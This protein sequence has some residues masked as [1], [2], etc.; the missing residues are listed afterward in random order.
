[1]IKC[2]MDLVSIKLPNLISIILILIILLTKYFF[3]PFSGVLSTLGQCQSIHTVS[4]LN[5]K[6]NTYPS[7]PKA[8][9]KYNDIIYPPQKEGEPPR[10]AVSYLCFS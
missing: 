6:H 8:W 4:A 9:P 10:P 5:G 3:R 2:G 7:E 1:M